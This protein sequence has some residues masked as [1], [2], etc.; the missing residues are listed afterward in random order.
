MGHRWM[1]QKKRVFRLYSGL[2]LPL[3]ALVH[4]SHC[5]RDLHGGGCVGLIGKEDREAEAAE[6]CLG[7]LL[8]PCLLETRPSLAG[9]GGGA[10]SG[11]KQQQLLHTRISERRIGGF[12]RLLQKLMPGIRGI[13]PGES[14]AIV[15]IRGGGKRRR[16]GAGAPEEDD[17]QEL[18]KDRRQFG[19]GEDLGRAEEDVLR[20]VSSTTRT[21]TAN[22][23]TFDLEDK[24]I[25]DIHQ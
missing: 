5:S 18:K 7:D 8:H 3:V 22:G 1:P 21:S 23:P 9:Q 16:K 2:F 12:A 15:A 19:H 6:A 13:G 17:L 10:V 14:S 25:N 11:I 4:I 24:R 20:E